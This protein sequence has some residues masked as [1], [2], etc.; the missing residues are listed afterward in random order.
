MEVRAGQASHE[1]R[2]VS[3]FDHE[4]QR[5]TARKLKRDTR[6]MTNIGFTNVVL[7]VT[8]SDLL[9][10]RR[11]AYL[12][13]AVSHMK[14]SGL[15]VWA[16]PWAVG[17]VFGGEGR[18]YFAE[19][20]EERRPDNP[21]LEALVDDFLGTV[22]EIGVDTVFW[23]EPEFGDACHEGVEM[24]F[25]RRYTRK[26]G[27]LALASVV[28]LPASSTAAQQRG[29]VALP[30]VVEIGVELYYPDPEGMISEAK[31]HEVMVARAHEV[32]AIADAHGKRAHAWV[33]N[34]NISRGGESMIGEHV[35]IARASGVDIAIWGFHGCES[36]PGFI[37]PDQA[38][39]RIM[40]N[41]TIGALALRQ[42][43]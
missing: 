15:E 10:K 16:D 33:Q 1:R 11:K 7:C 35:A 8:E 41:A 32:R 12:N 5:P 24:D 34:F 9:D 26:A 37:R 29:V 42:R 3:Y 22:K 31:R 23:D 28:C 43:G 13:N 6:E 2:I 14:E 30:D 27:A 36:V 38:P 20:G 17:G 18:S 40:W 4:F 25:L 39:S 19:R 21:R